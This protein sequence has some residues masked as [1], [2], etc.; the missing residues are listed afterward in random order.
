MLN[1][2]WHKSCEIIPNFMP[3]YPSKDTQPKV[4]IRFNNGKEH[5]PYL[6]Y[7]KGPMQGF[8]WDIYGDDFLQVELAIIALSKA[9]APVD[10]SPIEF[11]IEL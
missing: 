5:M 9:P 2:P 6:R 10:V 4:V 1:E 11:K 3:K 7:S 8:S